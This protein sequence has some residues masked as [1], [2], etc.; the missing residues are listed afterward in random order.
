MRIVLKPLGLFFLVVVPIITLIVIGIRSKLMGAPPVVAA[1]AVAPAPTPADMV[2][3]TQ[4]TDDLRPANIQEELEAR[5]VDR[6]TPSLPEKDTK[7]NFLGEST[8][9]AVAGDHVYRHAIKNGWF[10]MEIWVD[11]ETANDLVMTYYG[12]D[13]GAR[14]FDILVDGTKI[15][16]QELNNQHPDQFMDVTYPI[17]LKLTQGKQK[18]RLRLQATKE[19]VGGVWDVWVVRHK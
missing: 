9:T 17:P 16:S 12:G 19:I 7:R 3:P 1:T 2:T 14:A 11:P 13:S 4:R 5:E 15:G 8:E 18:V 6:Y 10:S